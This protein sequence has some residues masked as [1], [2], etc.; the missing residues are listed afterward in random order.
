MPDGKVIYG[1]C[2]GEFGRYNV[3]TG[4]EYARC[5]RHYGAV[6][7][8][9]FAP[10]GKSLISGGYDRCIRIWET[11]SGKQFCNMETPCGR[12]ALS[13]DGRT[14]AVKGPENR[15]CLLDVTTGRERLRFPSRWEGMLCPMTFSPDG[16]RLAGPVPRH[17]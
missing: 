8:L 14:L 16:Q 15:I 3:E 12:M 7:A 17:C 1:D 11:T 5:L 4:Q 2:K 9:A 10:D 6:T 13:A